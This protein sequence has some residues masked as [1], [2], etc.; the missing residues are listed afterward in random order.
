MARKAKP[1]IHWQ[2]LLIV[3]GYT[4]LGSLVVLGTIMLVFIG[5]GYIFDLESGS[6]Q[7]GGLILLNSKPADVPIF[8]NGED[9]KKR[10]AARLQMRADTYDVQLIKAGYRDWRKSLIVEPSQVTYSQ[11]PMMIPDDIRAD[12]LADLPAPK[13]FSQSPN[14]KWLA[15]ISGSEVKVLEAEKT[16]LKTVYSLPAVLAAQQVSLSGL[17]W[18]R[19]EEHLML[20]LAS[21]AGPNALVI[22]INNPS[23][24][25][26]IGSLF[27]IKPDNLQFS[28]KDWQQ[29]YW[30]SPEGLRRVNLSSRTVSAVLAEKVSH[31][32]VNKDLVVLV[33]NQ[34]SSQSVGFL[35]GDQLKL[36]VDNLPPAN[37][38][39]YH[40]NY[41]N[42]QWLVL[43]DQDAKSASL[44][45]SDDEPGLAIKPFNNI[46]VSGLVISPDHRFLVMQ[47]G[48]NFATY[49]FEYERMSR[50]NLELPQ[51]TNLSWFDN[52][53]L[54]G[55]SGGQTYLFEF[56][57]GNLEPIAAGLADAPAF[58]TD[59]RDHIYLL[60]QNSSSGVP[61]LQTVQLKRD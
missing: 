61:S 26:D 2:R 16:Q 24:V 35:D 11:Y 44:Y 21:P 7:S 19:D 18:A 20:T 4:V 43:H 48:P 49:D 56:D 37:R 3:A 45:P 55:N 50:F 33:Q 41:D 40:V 30:L 1:K 42:R 31:L 58:G 34:A 57:G 9:T 29:L 47:N 54:L 46:P 59:N 53:H 32:S 28:P 15:V 27:G 5:K 10:T 22:N 14:K 52:F 6:F 38:A 13:N 60:G 12:N 36:V 51:I 17:Y 25:F 23:E 8:V 39:A